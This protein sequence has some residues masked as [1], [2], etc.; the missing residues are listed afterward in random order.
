MTGE[1]VGTQGGRGREG[2]G[3][4]LTVQCSWFMVHDSQFTVHGSRFAVHGSRSTIVSPDGSSGTLVSLQYLLVA[5]LVQL[6]ILEYLVVGPPV[7]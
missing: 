6:A 5:P 3:G 4:D 7:P 1:S 2:R